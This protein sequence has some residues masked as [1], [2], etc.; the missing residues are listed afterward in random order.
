VLGAD[1]VEVAQGDEAEAEE[2][3]EDFG[4]PSWIGECRISLSVLVRRKEV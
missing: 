4:F 2:L 1:E 3:R